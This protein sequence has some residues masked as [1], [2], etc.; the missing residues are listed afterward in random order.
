MSL[1]F[2]KMARDIMSK[3]L[4]SVEAGD[5]LR[6]CYQLMK[7][8]GIRHLPV[9]HQH[10]EVVGILSDRDLQRAMVRVSDTPDLLQSNLNP[11]ESN[12][13]FPEGAIAQD[14]MSWPVRT[15]AE[16][17]SLEATAEMMLQEKLSALLVKTSN[18][19]IHGIITTDDLLE[20]LVA[21]LRKTSE[22]TQDQPTL[23]LQT[24]L[25]DRKDLSY[26]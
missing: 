22:S 14:Y 11:E 16:S 13:E 18:G 17:Q 21:L 15:V 12:Y 7:E 6:K 5:S 8:N 25:L 1:G 20:L 24:F 3:D 4:I 10:N 2:E 23:T 19:R 26:F 9:T